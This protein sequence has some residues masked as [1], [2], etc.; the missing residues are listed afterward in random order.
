MMML[1]FNLTPCLLACILK[2]DKIK[3]VIHSV[4][5]LISMATES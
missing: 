4:L 5:D 2:A 3:S 1:I